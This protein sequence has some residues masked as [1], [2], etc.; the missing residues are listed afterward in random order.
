VSRPDK[1]PCVCELSLFKD[2]SA[3][4]KQH[5]ESA[6]ST[7]RSGN[8]KPSSLSSRETAKP[9][10]SGQVPELVAEHQRLQV[11]FAQLIDKEDERIE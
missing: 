7:G 10:K 2:L 1:H 8:R 9:E 6:K 4:R 11:A 5:S 3:T